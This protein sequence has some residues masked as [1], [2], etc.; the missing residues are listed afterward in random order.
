MGASGPAERWPP[1]AIGSGQTV[2]QPKI[3]LFYAA[4]SSNAQP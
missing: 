4:R 2:D 3:A 1:A